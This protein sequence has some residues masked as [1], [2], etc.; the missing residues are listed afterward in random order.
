M[1]Y[2]LGGVAAGIPNFLLPRLHDAGWHLLPIERTLVSSLLF[3]GNL[4]GLLFWGAANDRFGRLLGIRCGLGLMATSAAATFLA[5][6][7]GG[8]LGARVLT[9]FA[10]GAVMNSSFVLM[11]E[12]TPPQFRVFAKSIQE[13][14]FS[15]GLLWSAVVAYLVRDADWHLLILVFLPVCPGM[16]AAATLPESPRYLLARGDADGALRVLSSIG[17]KAGCPLPPDAKL[18]VPEGCADSGSAPRVRW[19]PLGMC[20]AA[21]RSCA[22][23]GQLWH[24]SLRRRTVLVCG[25]WLGSTLVYYGVLYAPSDDETGGEH[26][27]GNLTANGTNVSETV[28]LEAA[29]REPV[30]YAGQVREGDRESP[31]PKLQAGAAHLRAQASPPHWRSVAGRG[32]CGS[33][34]RGCCLL[35]VA[36]TEL[37]AAR[38]FALALGRRSAQS[39]SC[40]RTC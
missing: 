23:F 24:R 14:G 28:A 27:L 6:S 18:S 39:S 7:V 12:L 9:G 34:A 38:V 36:T 40:R 25:A 10:N 2:G 22:T 20:R 15:L 21:V 26:A 17:R 11:A 5:T 8:L 29:K 32:C 13:S 1:C 31:P 33:C 30:D 4:I 16:V 37:D 3:F 19:T 35:A